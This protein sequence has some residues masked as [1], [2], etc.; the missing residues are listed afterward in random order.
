MQGEGHSL[1]LIGPEKKKTFKSHDK[2]SLQFVKEKSTLS[3][4]YETSL[5]IIILLTHFF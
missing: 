4:L 2:A 1:T 3:L 5:L